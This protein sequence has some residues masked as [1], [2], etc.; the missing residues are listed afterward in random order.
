[1]RQRKKE[2]KKDQQF[3]SEILKFRIEFGSKYIKDEE[4]PEDKSSIES[5]H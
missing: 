5:N 1:M 4:D 2:K 3:C